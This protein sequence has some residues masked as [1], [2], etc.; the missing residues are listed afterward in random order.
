VR[1][2]REELAEA[3]AR[4]R[5]QDV[6]GGIGYIVGVAGLG[7]WWAARSRPREAMKTKVQKGDAAR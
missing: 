4:A 6:I 7:L 3:R 5:V 1:P 2:L